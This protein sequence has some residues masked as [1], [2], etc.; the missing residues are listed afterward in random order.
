MGKIDIKLVDK[1]TEI[2]SGLIKLDALYEKSGIDPG[3]QWLY[4]NKDK[5]IDIPLLLDDYIIIH[6]GEKIFVGDANTEMG[7]N[8]LVRN[9][10][11][12]Q[13]NGKHLEPGIKTAKLSG[14]ELRKLDTE[15]D[16]SKL[17]TDLSGQVDVFIQDDWV[18]VIQ[19]RDCYLTI[20]VSGDGA[21]DLEECARHGRKPPKGQK[22]YKIRIDGE[23]YKVDK[24]VLTGAAILA[25]SSGKTFDEW[26]LNQKF[27]GGRRKPVEEEQEVDFSQPGI[28]RFETIKKQAQQGTDG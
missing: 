15:L 25:L 10:V 28:E 21:I 23:K 22:H 26:T 27:H 6:G 19:E 13:F 7:E 9:P 16:A 14:F 5:D 24:P 1:P 11:C 20:P 18:L 2:E 3:R 17:F 8:P 4:L 12:P